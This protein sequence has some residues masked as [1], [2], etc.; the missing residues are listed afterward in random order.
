[1]ID[2]QNGSVFKLKQTDTQSVMP[3]VEP[4]LIDG[5]QVISAY[6]SVR[7]CVI[8]TDKRVIAVNVQ[9]TTGKKRDY[10]SLPY[11]KLSAYSVETAGVG[12]IDSELELWYSGLGKVRFEFAGKS[13]ILQIGQMIARYQM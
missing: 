7:D 2:F 13:N 12:D 4:L 10:S 9:G 1:M 3:L 5:E 11:A 6:K 8:V